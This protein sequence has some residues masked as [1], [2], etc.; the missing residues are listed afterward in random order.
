[1]KTN[2]EILL[3]YAYGLI[4]KKRYTQRDLDKKLKTRQVATGDDR[5]KVIARLKE[6]NYLNDKEFANDYIE[7][8]GKYN[9]RGK[10]LLEL[11]L[12]IK[13]ID[14]TIIKNALN[15]AN[16]DSIAAAHE[17]IKRK[18]KSLEK[19]PK[20]KRK[21]KIFYMLAARGFDLETIYKVAKEC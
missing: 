8:R 2:Y 18:Q 11:E 3:E 1:M 6:L 7:M 9:P 20:E 4:A 12:K 21:A 13:G 19:L 15:E 5:E 17:V 10:K 16:I 14:K